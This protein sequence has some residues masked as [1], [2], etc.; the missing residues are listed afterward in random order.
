MPP[1]ELRN[2]RS[3]NVNQD[4]SICDS[5]KGRRVALTGRMAAMDRAA[6]IHLL[7]RLGAVPVQRV[8]S[9]TDKLI[10]GGDGWPLRRNGKPTR[11]LSRAGLLQRQGYPIEILTE[12]TF[13]RRLNLTDEDN[14]ACR[15]YTIEQISQMVKISGLRLRR[16]MMLG[17]IEPAQV[18]FG[19]DL[20][21]YR[22]VASIR[23]LW[24]L[25][26][27]GCDLRT[28]QR[29]L[30]RLG[31]WT[32]EA[33]A[34]I[35]DVQRFGRSLALRTSDGGLIDG[36]GQRLFVF[37]DH[38]PQVLAWKLE[39]QIMTDPDRAFQQAAELEG[40]DPAAAIAAYQDWL[41]RFGMDA[42]VCFNLANLLCQQGEVQLA[43]PL[44]RSATR[45]APQ[46]AKLWNNF[47]LALAT[48]GDL[49]GAS[50]MIVQ[51]IA[52]DPNYADAYY[53]AGDILDCLGE[54][55]RAKLMWLRYLQYDSES[56]H[57]QYAQSRCGWRVMKVA[58]EAL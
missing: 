20:F 31:R 55:A 17:L 46:D 50:E 3:P 24:R 10:I 11:N 35:A 58:D 30:S 19:V 32:D 38:Q 49:R 56:E 43:L 36:F 37:D 28:L 15:L 42:T 51:A 18:Q 16:W 48:V 7:R 47:A 23:D 8:S 41:D 9:T 12:A 54:S 5:W 57:A 2:G 13:L 6:A 39:S 26:T 29:S 53:N 21:E 45:L 4:E 1:N 40:R 14:I 22:Q 33:G 27:S 25:V 44:Y 52:C 34:A